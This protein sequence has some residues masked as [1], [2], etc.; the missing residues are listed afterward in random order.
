MD[1]LDIVSPLGG[2]MGSKEPMYLQLMSKF[3]DSIQS[4]ALPASTKLPTNRELAHLLKVDRS[5]V[6]R[7][8]SE[9]ASAGLIES[10]VGRGTYVRGTNA[11]SGTS[12]KVNYGEKFNW[13]EKFSR[14]SALTADVLSRQPA[15]P[16]DDEDFVTFSGG[17]PA[18]DSFPH[19][20]FRGVLRELT[21]SARARELFDYS[22]AEGNAKL[23]KAVT[24]HLNTQGI[25]CGDDELLIL[26]GSQQ[27]IDLI[28]SQF[29]DGG[30]SVVIE[31]PTY[32]WALCN[33]RARQARLL[34]VDVDSDGM[35]TDLLEGYLTRFNPKL[36][37]LMPDFQNP[38]GACFSMERRLR[39]L[40]IAGH[41]GVPIFEDNFA[42]ELRYDG[43][44]LPSLRSLPKGE[45]FVIHQGTFSKALCPGLRVGW[46]VAP[47]EVIS[48]LKIAKRASDLSTNSIAQVVLAS[49][50]EGGLYKEHLARV[51]SVYKRRRDVMLASFNR[52]VAPH[53]LPR[54]LS[55]HRT[56]EQTTCS[57]PQGGLFIWAKLPDGFSSRDLLKLAEQNGV[58]F[59]PGDLY[60]VT[61]EKT[62]YF[63]LCF[64][65]TD[66]ATIERGMERLGVAVKQLFER[67]S[68]G[69]SP[70]DTGFKN[71]E[72]VLV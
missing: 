15:A 32:F 50:L 67:A 43:E 10:Y 12:A 8:Y 24:Q 29:V 44:P 72:N 69:R 62:P 30:D 5:T 27:G 60:F 7:A 59:S 2:E 46:L 35:R 55:S 45:Q 19:E 51:T 40:E 26:S 52:H 63:R 66:E 41:Y 28:A 47:A 56:P 39:L 70:Q 42:S 54:P 53:T 25:Q 3:R 17:S 20:D 49:F 58:S 65:Q 21:D 33:F 71:N 13:N 61:E 16:S 11:I 37:Y 68:R 9:L 1:W 57:V 6:A 23:R 4:G 48:R 64:I 22:P 31:Q 18:S 14:A 34:A 38:T 36:I